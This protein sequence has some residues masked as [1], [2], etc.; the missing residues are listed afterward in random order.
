M[1]DDVQKRQGPI[2][3]MLVCPRCKSKTRFEPTSD[4]QVVTCSCGYRA[5]VPGKKQAPTPLAEGEAT[6]QTPTI[7]QKVQ[8]LLPAS[9]PEDDSIR[10]PGATFRN[11]LIFISIVFILIGFVSTGQ[12]RFDPDFQL[13]NRFKADNAMVCSP[14]TGPVEM[15]VSL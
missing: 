12:S 15:G 7:P 4:E 10:T 8:T 9:W 13:G 11:S 6:Q 14:K 5:T 1:V 3:T 2:M